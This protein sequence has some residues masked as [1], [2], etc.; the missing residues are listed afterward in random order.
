MLSHNKLFHRFLS[1]NTQ[2]F[3]ACFCAYEFQEY[4][5]LYMA[6]FFVKI[7]VCL[8]LKNLNYGKQTN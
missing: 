3:L 6:I 5:G 4:Y 8:T 2:K 7:C 1:K